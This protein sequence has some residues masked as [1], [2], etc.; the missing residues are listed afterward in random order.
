M[1]KK[2]QIPKWKIK[3]GDQVVVIT[4]NNKGMT[5][6]V[7]DVLRQEGTAVVEGVRVVK[8]HTKPSAT[9]P[10]GGI[11]EK[12]APINISNL[13]IADPKTGEATRV[14]RRKEDGKLV[15][16]AKKSGQALD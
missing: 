6:R 16:F 10:E 14:G 8:R 7:L 2:Q 1:M 12:E 11:I 3:K 13:A 5:G 9:N 4:G 15:R